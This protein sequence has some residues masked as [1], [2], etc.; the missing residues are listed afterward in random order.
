[1]SSCSH[2]SL[3]QIIHRNKEPH[4]GTMWNKTIDSS[5]GTK[6][7]MLTGLTELDK[8]ELDSLREENLQLKQALEQ[9]VFYM[10]FFQPHTCL[11]TV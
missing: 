1:M 5:M 7:P 4:S 8:R 11:C 9:V 10:F 2:C 3:F 6:K